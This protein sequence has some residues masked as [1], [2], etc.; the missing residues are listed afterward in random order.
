M[1][2]RQLLTNHWPNVNI[3][4]YKKWTAAV[5]IKNLVH[6]FKVYVAITKFRS[7]QKGVTLE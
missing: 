4:T 5:I 2:V 3:Q 7:H 6:K 1:G